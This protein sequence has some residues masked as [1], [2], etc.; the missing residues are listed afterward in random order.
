MSSAA[1]KESFPSILDLKALTLEWVLTNGSLP[2]FAER[3][4]FTKPIWFKVAAP[5]TVYRGQGG[6]VKGIPKVG[7]EDP[8][9]LKEGVRPVIATSK[10]K[11][12]ILR[13]M[14]KD[15][16][17]FEIEVQPGIRYIDVERVFT[18]R[19]GEGKSYLFVPGDVI[20]MVRQRVK[21]M[22][23]TYWLKPNL[24]HAVLRNLFLRRLRGYTKKDGTVV[25]PEM[26]IIL[27]GTQGVFEDR[28]EIE[29][30]KVFKTS[31]KL[32]SAVGK[33]RVRTFR[34]TSKRR[35]KNGRGPTRKSK[36]YGNRRP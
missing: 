2:G 12:S 23:P 9:V 17:L 7:E 24:P 33:G 13:F 36:N 16:C 35:S 31:Y 5:F 19:N 15:C 29:P 1:G 32:S 30:G 18:S 28:T 26:E 27:D 25:P 11:D 20:E 8:S 10:S 6:E 34:R 3:V 21:G 4:E 22:D 14:G